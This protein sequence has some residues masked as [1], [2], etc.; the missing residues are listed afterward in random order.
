MIPLLLA[1]LLTLP[2]VDLYLLIQLSDSLG[3]LNVLMLVLGTGVIGGFIARSEGIDVL[4]RL[5]SSVSL[6]EVSRNMLEGLLILVGGFG[7]LLP[8]LLTDG[9]GACLI[10]KPFRQRIAVRISD[11]LKSSTNVEVRS[12][13]F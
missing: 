11:R 4:I 12:F 8:G 10:F 2:F 3:F 1:V 5:S 7:L 9:L 13:S 6:E